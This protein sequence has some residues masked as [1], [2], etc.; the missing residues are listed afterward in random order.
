MNAGLFLL[1]AVAGGLGAGL[2]YV[3]DVLV[4]GRVA[5]R[6]PRG[7]F[8]V[9]VAG[10]FALGLVTGLAGG[11]LPADLVAVLGTGLLGGFTT[12]STV[13]VDTALLLRDGERRRAW[14]NIAGTVV[15][16]VAAAALGL[17]LGAL[18]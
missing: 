2:R 3:V 18:A 16:C 9:N 14:V 4:T 17:V 8:V 1:I 15:A 12:F 5:A 10:S 13:S 7:I 6:F 11:I